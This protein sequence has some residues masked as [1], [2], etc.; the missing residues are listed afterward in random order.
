[1][2]QVWIYL[3]TA[4]VVMASLVAA[5][6]DVWKYKVYNILTLPLLGSGLLYHLLAGGR[7]GFQQ[8]LYGI[9]FG[10]GVLLIPHLMGGMSAGDLKLLAGIGAWLKM[11]GVVFVFVV[12]GLLSATY[13]V[14]LLVAHR[15]SQRSVWLN[16][17]VMWQRFV[18]IGRSIAAEDW[19]E[20][21]LQRPQPEQRV[22]P[23][24][25]MV[26]AGILATVLLVSL[27]GRGVAR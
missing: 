27:S 16:M 8:S 14:V 25:V 12:A 24:A 5:V 23:F 11:P 2:G 9:V 13:S 4:V 18:S 22:I 3:P 20:A 19:V 10:I 17:K 1:M 6:T 15:N 7:E 26:A 21:E